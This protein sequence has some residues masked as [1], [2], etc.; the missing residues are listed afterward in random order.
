M[1]YLAA[2]PEAN[3]SNNAVLVRPSVLRVENVRVVTDAVAGT[4]E[5]R[6]IV[7]NE[8]LFSGCA[9]FVCVSYVCLTERMTDC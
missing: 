2:H 8:G 3:S 4:V 9:S 1:Q 7:H 5:L 6:T